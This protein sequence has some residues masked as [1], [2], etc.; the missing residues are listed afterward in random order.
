MTAKL[1]V[2]VYKSH[3]ELEKEDLAYW[4][5]QTPESRLNEVEILRKEAGKFLYAY[6]ARLRR[7]ITVTRKKL[8]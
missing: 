5:S 2:S 1:H 6:P 7:I 8:G 3:E 4:K